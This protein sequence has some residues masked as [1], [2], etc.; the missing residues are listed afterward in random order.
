MQPLPVLTDAHVRLLEPLQP[1]GKVPKVPEIPKPDIALPSLEVN[2]MLTV[3][4]AP[5]A[6]ETVPETEGVA[7]IELL[8]PVGAPAALMGLPD[9]VPPGLPPLA[10]MLPMVP[11]LLLYELDPQPDTRS[12]E[13]TPRRSER[14]LGCISF[15]R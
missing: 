12:S 2:V 5:T 8:V 10:P 9:G 15:E 13:H 14:R 3:C 1:A 11:R 6:T 4:F 7:T